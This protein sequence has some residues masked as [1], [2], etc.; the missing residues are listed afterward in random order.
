MEFNWTPVANLHVTLNFLGETEVSRLA[1]LCDVVQEV[2]STATPFE[3][4]LRGFGGFPDERHI[5]A[6]WV[7]VRNSRALV[8]LQDRLREELVGRD[9]PQEDRTYLPHLT[10]ARTRKARSGTDLISPYV[11]TSFGD[12]EVGGITLFES[13]MHG[14]H[15][16]YK[17]VE[18]F[19]LTGVPAE[20][21][22]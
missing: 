2:A 4:S 10:I 15:V 9:F 7:G 8:E 5:R 20:V 13:Q 19:A 17:P 3:T 14:P 22:E 11:R 6:L 18:R 16:V 12:I 21:L 1:D